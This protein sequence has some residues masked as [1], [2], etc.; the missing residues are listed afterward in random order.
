MVDA[1]RGSYQLALLSNTT[2]VHWEY[3]LSHYDSLLEMLTPH[4]V[5]HEIGLAKPDAAIFEHVTR[6]LGAAPADCL[7]IDDYLPYVEGARRAG[8]EAILFTGSAQ[9][10]QDLADHGVDAGRDQT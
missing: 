5:S 6:E 8:L 3:V 1:L 2:S 10:V 4:F 7:F 9:L